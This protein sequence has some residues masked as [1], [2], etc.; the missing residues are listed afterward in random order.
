MRGALSWETSGDSNGHHPFRRHSDACVSCISAG[1][2]VT[3]KGW[4]P[5]YLGFLL[6][7]TTICVVVQ[8]TSGFFLHLLVVVF[9]GITYLVSC[10]SVASC[11]FTRA[12]H[13]RQ[14]S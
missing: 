5:T 8:G 1:S 4:F 13:A 7:F 3:A 6:T 9:L 12:V 10:L 2:A 14:V 11:K